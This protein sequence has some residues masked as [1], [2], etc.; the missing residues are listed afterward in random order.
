[1]FPDGGF[2]GFATNF[3]T[4]TCEIGEL[5]IFLT[6][7]LESKCRAL[8]V[9]HIV[10][11]DGHR[12][13]IAIECAVVECTVGLIIDVQMKPFNDFEHQVRRL[14]VD[15]LVVDVGTRAEHSEVGD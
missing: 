8:V 5:Y 12:Q 4:T 10:E 2:Y 9:F 7:H 11:R 6:F 13:L 1:M 15:N 3:L 14:E